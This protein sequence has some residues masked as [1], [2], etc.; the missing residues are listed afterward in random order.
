MG[1]NSVI[2]GKNNIRFF[3]FLEGFIWGNI[4][5]QTGVSGPN[6]V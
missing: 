1:N 2:K 6:V 5:L 3:E 4:T